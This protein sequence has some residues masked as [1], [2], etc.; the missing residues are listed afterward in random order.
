MSA[1]NHR[2]E[3]GWYLFLVKVKVSICKE[4]NPQIDVTRAE[5]QNPL[6]ES[7]VLPWDHQVP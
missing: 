2:G 4:G 6:N 7:N 3:R 1:S 5:T